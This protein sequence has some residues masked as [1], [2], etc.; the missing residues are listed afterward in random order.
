MNQRASGMNLATLNADYLV[1]SNNIGKLHTQQMGGISS[2]AQS[3]KL[4]PKK[5]LRE[6]NQN[7]NTTQG[8]KS[9]TSLVSFIGNKFDKTVNLANIGSLSKPPTNMGT[10]GRYKK[11][12][13][14]A[15]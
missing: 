6:S 2:L 14:N 11:K 13:T 3:S 5:D 7:F 9:A 4:I 10:E 1:K 8:I 12:S 15:D